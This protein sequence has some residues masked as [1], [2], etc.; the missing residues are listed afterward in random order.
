MSV[1]ELPQTAC[2]LGLPLREGDLLGGQEEDALVQQNPEEEGLLVVARVHSLFHDVHASV[3]KPERLLILVDLALGRHPRPRGDGKLERDGL[4]LQCPPRD[5]LLA[6]SLSW[7]LAVLAWLAVGRSSS[8][9][10]LVRAQALRGPGQRAM[11]AVVHALGQLVARDVAPFLHTQ[12][13]Q[14]CCRPGQDRMGV[15]ANLTVVAC[16]AQDREPAPVCSWQC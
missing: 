11:V 13:A 8:T 14:V 2:G 10:V 9:A 7:G 1:A 16:V 4:P 5:R 12:L 6:W 3:V 15:R